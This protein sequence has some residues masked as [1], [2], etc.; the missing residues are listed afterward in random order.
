[1]KNRIS[2]LSLTA[3]AALLLAIPALAL[4]KVGD[5]APDFTLKSLD[6][7]TEITLSELEGKVVYLDF[8]ASWCAP[9]RRA[10]PEVKK[11][12]EE[13]ADKGMEVLAISLDRSPAPAIK[14]MAEQ[15]VGFESL[16]DAGGGAASRYGVRSIP[17]TVIV[18]P[19]GKVAYSMKGFNPMKVGELKETIEG[20]LAQVELPQEK[21]SEGTM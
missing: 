2:I 21:D 12:H 7:S 3:L 14:F 10:F 13:Y 1:M 11:L 19:D 16:F 4:P 5:E 8:W 15:G 9:C 17:T 20:L 18:G 6:G